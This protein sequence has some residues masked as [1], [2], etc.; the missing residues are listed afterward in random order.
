[1]DWVLRVETESQVANDE[2]EFDPSRGFYYAATSWPRLLQVYRQL[3]A[4]PIRPDDAF[5]DLGC[6]KGRALLVASRFPF[7]RLIGVDL[8]P[9]LLATAAANAERIRELSPGV[10]IELVESDAGLYEIPD[11]VMTIYLNNPFPSPVVEQVLDQL[12]ASVQRRPRMI[13][14]IYHSWRMEDAP[15]RRGFRMARRLG[16]VALFVLDVSRA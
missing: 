11:D 16:P 5:L 9:S 12:M 6:G 15:T 8:S 14:I 13:G 4:L 10:R 3:R 2:L 1:V 7:G